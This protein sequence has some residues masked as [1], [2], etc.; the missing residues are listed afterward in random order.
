MQPAFDYAGGPITERLAPA[1][2][3][4]LAEFSGLGMSFNICRG[5]LVSLAMFTA[6][7]KPTRRAN[8]KSKSYK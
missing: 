6:I 7:R 8:R 2:S 3:F 5:T 1:Q 4:R